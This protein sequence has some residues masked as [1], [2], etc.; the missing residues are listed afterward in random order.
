[1]KFS[2]F[3]DLHHYP[4][5]FMGGTE[6]DL[7]QIR[8]RAVRKNCA[9]VIHAGDFCHG[10]SE[11]RDYLSLYE[12]FP[13][14]T[15][16]CLGNHDTDN[17]SYEETLRLYRMPS[18]YYFF[19]EGG[20]RFIVC[21]T[22]YY[23]FDG[24]YIHYDLG[25]YYQHGSQRDYLPPDQLD[26][27]RET[28]SSASGSCVLISHASFERP[29]GVKN[30]DEVQKIINEA[31]KKKPHSVILCINGHHHRDYIRIL[32]GV[33]YFDLNS[34]SFDWLD[35]PH[36]LFPKELCERYRNLPHTVVFN[37]P[38]HAVI[39][40]DGTSIKIEGMESTM[41]MGVCRE[42]TDNPIYDAAGR[43]VVPRVQSAAFTLN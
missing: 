29:N 34:A 15:Y 25:N 17:T 12:Q 13:I 37:D 32:D 30:R 14:P 7:A 35:N 39:T 43:A 20:Y 31:N 42:Q 4:G 8:D 6:E 36:G 40:L 41:F 5:V 1:M 38:I 11:I 16:H 18:G 28:I 21:D 19:D 10:P 33:C 24:K 23:L 27:L 3:A 26:W 2:I 22:N 9:F